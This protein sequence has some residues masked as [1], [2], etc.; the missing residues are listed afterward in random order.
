[1]A[2]RLTWQLYPAT[3]IHVAEAPSFQSREPQNWRPSAGPGHSQGEFQNAKVELRKDALVQKK[4]WI[5]VDSLMIFDANFFRKLKIVAN[6]DVGIPLQTR[7]RGWTNHGQLG[8]A[9]N[10]TCLLSWLFGSQGCQSQ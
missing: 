7:P 9:Q 6:F 8:G 3:T 2:Q 10:P 1:M 5:H 4:R